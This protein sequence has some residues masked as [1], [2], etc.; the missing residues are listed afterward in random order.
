MTFLINKNI[1]NDLV[2]AFSYGAVISDKIGSYLSSSTFIQHMT[3]TFVILPI[4]S[5]F[6]IGIKLK[7]LSYE[8]Q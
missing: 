3:E 7:I 6:Y 8:Q 4:T 5:G 1:I 2:V